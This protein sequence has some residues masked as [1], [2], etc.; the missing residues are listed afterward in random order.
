[1]QLIM[2]VIIISVFYLHWLRFSDVTH[3]RSGF[4]RLEGLERTVWLRNLDIRRHVRVWSWERRGFDTVGWKRVFELLAVEALESILLLSSLVSNFLLPFV[5]CRI[6][7]SN[8]VLHSLNCLFKQVFLF[9]LLLLKFQ[10]FTLEHG[11]LGHSREHFSGEFGCSCLVFI[12][13]LGN[14][15][16]ALTAIQSLSSELFS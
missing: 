4:A 8:S 5:I 7:W 6:R 13:F 9:F 14:F 3:I 16:S 12:D 15:Q 11:Q 10:S 1:M 2:E